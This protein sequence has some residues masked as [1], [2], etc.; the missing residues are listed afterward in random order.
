[1]FLNVDD[2]SITDD[3]LK[4]IGFPETDQQQLPEPRYVVTLQLNEKRRHKEGIRTVIEHGSSLRVDRKKG[5]IVEYYLTLYCRDKDLMPLERQ[6]SQFTVFLVD[7]DNDHIPVKTLSLCQEM[8]QCL[9]SHN[10]DHFRL[11]GDALM[12]TGRV[13]IYHN[14]PAMWLQ[15]TISFTNQRSETETF[16]TKSVTFCGHDN[17]RPRPLK[18]NCREKTVKL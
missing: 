3:F 13:R 8:K 18:Q 6:S 11:T 14:S 5:K 16:T 9:E 17:G 7:R 12:Y 2:N 1:M 10:T 4:Q 15:V